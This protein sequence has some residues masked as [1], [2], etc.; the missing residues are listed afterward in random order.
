VFALCYKN[1]LQNTRK[2]KITRILTNEHRKYLFEKEKQTVYYEESP[3]TQGER[4]DNGFIIIIIII[5][6]VVIIIV[7]KHR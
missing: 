3:D 1:R 6:I 7:S 4:Q 5:I 2:K